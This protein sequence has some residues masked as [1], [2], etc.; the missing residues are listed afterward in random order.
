MSSG[1]TSVMAI[2]LSE[3]EKSRQANATE[4]ADLE[5]QVSAKFEA[6][7]AER[8]KWP[9]EIYEE[10]GSW[11][12]ATDPGVWLQVMGVEAPAGGAGTVEIP[13]FPRQRWITHAGRRAVVLTMLNVLLEL[14][15]TDEQWAL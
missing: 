6:L 1:V 2:G 3:C 14:D 8:N 12:A 13:Q 10:P 7:A 5:Q 11:C 9:E 4:L 15:L